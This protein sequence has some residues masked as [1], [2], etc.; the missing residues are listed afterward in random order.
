MT[1]RSRRTDAPGF[2]RWPARSRSEPW[3]TACLLRSCHSDATTLLHLQHAAIHS[4][5]HCGTA[6]LALLPLRRADDFRAR[7]MFRLHFLN[8]ER[9][10]GT[11]R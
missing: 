3:F 4:R 1:Q 9:C 2:L 5:R 6:R 11:S 8:S 10:L 7:C